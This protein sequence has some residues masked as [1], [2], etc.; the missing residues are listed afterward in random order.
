M[1][2]KTAT[3]DAEGSQRIPTSWLYLHYYEALNLL[4]RIE[5]ALRVFVYMTLKCHQ[6]AA[7]TNHQIPGED[8]EEGTIASIAK[9][10]IAQSEAFGYLGH[11]V[12]CPIMHLTS[13]ELAR[14]IASKTNW[15]LFKP[16]FMGSKEIIANK[17]EEIGAIRNS[18]A[19]F[20]PI[21]PDDVDVLKQNSKHVMI[22][23]EAMLSQA[24]AQRDVVPTNTPDDW[25]AHLNTLGSELCKIGFR[26]SKDE[27]WVRLALSYE[28][29]IVSVEPKWQSRVEYRVLTIVSRSFLTFENLRNEVV[30]L[31]EHVPFVRKHSDR[32][33][34]FQKTVSMVFARSTLAEGYEGVLS[35]LE[36]L[37][38][39]ISRETELIQ[40]DNLAR[41][42]V[43]QAV[44][45]DAVKRRGPDERTYWEIDKQSLVTKPDQNDP[46]EFWGSLEALTTSDFI[47]Q[48]SRYPWM[49]A[50][51]CEGE[52][53]F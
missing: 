7:W 33:P 42:E 30:Y 22:G 23:I 37:L 14:L 4:F 3:Q 48:T 15:P 43:V 44:S 41:G 18:L 39:D 52:V 53:P 45:A 46:P 50:Q 26:Q 40:Q 8:G 11:P 6:K 47:A 27:Q 12:S 28:C 25:Y 29:P 49:R 10:R 35:D 36:Q 31:Y 38:R 9:R 19:H 32:P 17:L 5:N 24:M 21:T 1:D 13:G 16:Y 34:E 51:V 20:R 2:W